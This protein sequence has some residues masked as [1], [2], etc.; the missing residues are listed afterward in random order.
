MK[1]KR[2]KSQEMSFA[3]V[4]VVRNLNNVVERVALKKGYLHKESL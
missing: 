4:E 2:K 3:P 1:K